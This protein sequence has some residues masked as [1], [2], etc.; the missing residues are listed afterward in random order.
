MALFRTSKGKPFKLSSGVESIYKIDCSGFSDEDWATIA[1]LIAERIPNFSS[2]VGVPTGGTKLA[3]A[4]KQYI[5]SDTGAV[6][7][8]VDDVL[9]TGKSV[10]REMEKLGRTAMAAVVFT[11]G[12]KLPE[13]VFA[14]FPMAK[15]SG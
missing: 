15:W 8:V 1:R 11:R 3:L 7:L 14:L 9:T 5:S 6:P 4:L 10:L 12:G 13:K 2:V